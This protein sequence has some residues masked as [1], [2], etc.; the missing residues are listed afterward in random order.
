MG[1]LIGEIGNIVNHCPPLRWV[2]RLGRK[3]GIVHFLHVIKAKGDKTS[4]QR[5]KSFQRFYNEHQEEFRKVSE[6]LEDDFSRRTFEQVLEFRRTEDI[7][8]LKGVV[9]EPEYFQKDI[10]SPIKGE[11]FVDGGAYV[12]DSVEN[13]IR[14][15]AGG[16]RKSMLGSRMKL[17]SL[18]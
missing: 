3:L 11:V 4:E 12:G 17:T 6:M 7:N 9:T 1:D 16:I 5:A 18:Q 8:A 10:F 13:F 15:F 14:L 2:D